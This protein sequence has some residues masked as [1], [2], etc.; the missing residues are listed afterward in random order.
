GEG[1][2]NRDIALLEATVP[3]PDRMSTQDCKV[4]VNYDGIYSTQIC[5]FENI[6]YSPVFKNFRNLSIGLS[7]GI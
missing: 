6:L 4:I 2:I 7:G 5:A 1:S 3:Q